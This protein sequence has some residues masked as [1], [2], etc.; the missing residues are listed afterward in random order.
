LKKTTVNE[1]QATLQICSEHR[2][3]DCTRLEQAARAALGSELGRDVTDIEWKRVQARVAEWRSE[4]D[5]VLRKIQEIQL[6]TPAPVVQA[7]DVILRDFSP[8][9][10]QFSSDSVLPE[11]PQLCKQAGAVFGEPMGSCGLADVG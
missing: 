9:S 2:E 6:A 11:Y 1:M 8:R 3:K 5:V 7:I 4:Q 10:R